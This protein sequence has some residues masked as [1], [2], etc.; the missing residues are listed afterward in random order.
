MQIT[1]VTKDYKNQRSFYVNKINDLVTKTRHLTDY[2]FIYG[3][4]DALL[5]ITSKTPVLAYPII[6][7]VDTF[8]KQNGFM[9]YFSKNL[10]ELVIF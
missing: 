2:E 10:G 9:M 1:D 5:I 8:C 4:E 3:S 6:K 7:Y